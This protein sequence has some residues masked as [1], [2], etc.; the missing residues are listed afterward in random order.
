MLSVEKMIDLDRVQLKIMIYERDVSFIGSVEGDRAD[1][2]H[3]RA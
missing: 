2:Q 3:I 1:G